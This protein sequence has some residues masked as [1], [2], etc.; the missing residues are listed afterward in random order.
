VS[1][2]DHVL[3]AGF[4]FLFKLMMAR[5]QRGEPCSHFAAIKENERVAYSASRVTDES[6]AQGRVPI[7]K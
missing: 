7:G 6:S 4:D 3:C 2:K 1:P 5:Q